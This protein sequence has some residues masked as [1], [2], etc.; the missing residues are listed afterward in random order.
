[1]SISPALPCLPQWTPVTDGLPAAQDPL[2][3][4]SRRLLVATDEV[5][6]GVTFAYC[7][8]D[9]TEGPNWYTACAS[10][11]DLHRVTHYALPPLRPGVEG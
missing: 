4:R 2:T 8:L 6:D 9:A 10:G 11:F 3:G 5:D 1:M 7:F